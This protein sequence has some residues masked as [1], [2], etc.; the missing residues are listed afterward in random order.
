MPSV[1]P[2]YSN[3]GG[4]GLVQNPNGR[5]L[6]EGTLA[7]SW[8]HNEPYLR[9][10][11]IAYP[12]DWME[13]SYQ[14]A[15]INNVL[16]SPVEEFSGSQS[17][18]D[19]SF[20][21]KIR[22]IKESNLFPQVSIGIRDLGGTGLFSSEYIT[23]NKYF[24]NNLDFTAGIG[25]GILSG[26]TLGTNIFNQLSDRFKNRGGVEA[27]GGKVNFNSLFTGDM[28]YFFG[29][30][31]FLEGKRGLRIKL[32]YD[33]TNYDQESL[34]P[35]ESNSK[36][37]FGIVYPVSKNLLTKLSITRG[38][39]IN[40]G[41]SYSLGLGGKNPINQSKQPRLEIANNDL[42]KVVTNRS[43]SNLYRASLKYLRDDG[44]N[45]QKASINENTLEVVYAQS[46]YRNFSRSSGRVID[47]LDQIS[48]DYIN[49]FRVSEINGGLGIAT[50]DLDRDSFQRYKKFNSP[51]SVN[52]VIEID[53]YK[54]T[55]D[56]HLFNPLTRYPAFFGS[57]SP[58]LRSQI[59]GPDGFYFGDLKLTF[60]S[61][62]LLS[63][64][65]S[66]LTVASYGLINNLDELKLPSDSILPHVRTEIVN[67]LKGSTDFSIRRMQ[68]NYY[69]QPSK[70]IFLKLSG[71][72]MESMFGGYG[73]ESLYKPFNKNYGVGLEVWKAHQR[74][75]DQMFEFQDYNVLT[76]HMTFYYHEPNTHILF[77]VKGGRYLARDSGFTFDFSRRFR[78][79]LRIGAF[80]SLTDISAEE[81]GEGSFDKGFYFWVPVD[82]FSSRY[83]KR[84]FGWGLRPLTRD[85]AQSL[86]HGHPLWGVTDPSSR[87]LY[88][89][90]LQDFYD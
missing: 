19:K 32:E 46:K 68:L 25:W 48:P 41:F 67:Y 8:S 37:N 45:L 51:N 6:E 7:F 73:F 72:I 62:L 34:I 36:I 3:Y 64:N 49:R 80:F 56:G 77:K 59:G 39:Q 21:I 81:F 84:T 17:L 86:I 61:E 11:I 50:L 52:E 12:F 90:H 42:V 27:G 79:G 89:R 85:G 88:E 1:Q 57:I 38:N 63:R 14:Y 29:A 40:F 16:Y 70:S 76:G 53:G 2:S 24:G 69:I 71:G 13:A 74:D 44:I 4:L 28:G 47:I 5:F 75:Y 58:D 35:L 23:F 20:D 78:S 65:I 9:G 26:N 87:H 55:N 82:I 66:L 33:G 60:N 18:K 10:S 30:E 83:F 31:Y 15:D 22:L 54:F 43:E